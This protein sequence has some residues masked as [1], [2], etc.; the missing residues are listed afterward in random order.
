[1]TIAIR[2]SCG[3]GWREFVEMICPT[4]EAKYFCK[5]D[6]TQ[7]RPAGKSP[8]R[9]VQPAMLKIPDFLVVRQRVFPTCRSRRAVSAVRAEAEM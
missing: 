2:P 6:S 5:G 4:D 7:N 9:A 1:V 8:D 3:L